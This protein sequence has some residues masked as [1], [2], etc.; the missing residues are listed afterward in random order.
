MSKTVC[1]KKK[2]AYFDFIDKKLSE[3][4]QNLKTDKLEEFLK[5]NTVQHVNLEVNWSVVVCC[6]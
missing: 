3:K 1:E 4:H 6:L 5:E 2:E